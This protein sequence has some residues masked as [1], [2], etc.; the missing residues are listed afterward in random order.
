MFVYKYDNGIIYYINISKI[1]EFIHICM[2]MLELT[3]LFFTKNIIF[4]Q[5][6]FRI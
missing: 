6:K 1:Y 2:E 4:F 3:C 5:I